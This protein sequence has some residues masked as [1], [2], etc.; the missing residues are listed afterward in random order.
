MSKTDTLFELVSSLST[1]EK[2]YIGVFSKK[3]QVNDYLN[4]FGKVS[5]QAKKIKKNTGENSKNLKRLKINSSEKNYIYSFILKALRSFHESRNVD[6][7]IREMLI[8]AG[9]LLEKRL[10]KQSLKMLQRAKKQV[11]GFD[12]HLL[13]AEIIQME[14]QVI[15]EI[16][17]KD[18]LLHFDSL[19]EAFGSVI[20]LY[21]NELAAASLQQ[22][23]RLLQRRHERLPQSKQWKYSEQLDSLLA[24]AKST[25][26]FSLLHNSLFARA[27]FNHSLGRFAGSAAVYEELI[28]LWETRPDRI[29]GENMLFKKIIFNYLIACHRLERFDVYPPMIGR[30]R[31]IPCTNTEEEAE[32]F[33]NLQ[34]MELLLLMNTDGYDQLPRIEAEISAGLRQ[35]RN[36]INKA[37]ELAFYHNIAMA[38]FL[39]EDWK[40]SMGWI[41]KIMLEKKSQ[42]RIDLQCFA[43]LLRLVLWYETG[44]YDLLE[45]ET[46][47]AQRYLRKNGGWTVFESTVTKLVARLPAIPAEEKPVLFR[48][49]FHQL[50][51]I[52]ENTE[53]AGVPGLDELICWM[54]SHLEGITI[55]EVMKIENNKSVPGSKK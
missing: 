32:Q 22:R 15:V 48:K 11:M 39:C 14:I 35:Y 34:M 55:R 41:E 3:H 2:R 42:Q 45:Y 33:Q 9:L 46:I 38:H 8:N 18:A 54:Q 19:T 37:H 29:R 36:K 23:I 6:I 28:A 21:P 12:R 4:L 51:K 5:T 52:K 44:K 7:A 47:N 43:R 31:A 1:A 27:M 26:N 24:L 17:G 10:F 13:L 25:R 49:A 53:T 50:Q 30:I 40:S 16:S 20:G